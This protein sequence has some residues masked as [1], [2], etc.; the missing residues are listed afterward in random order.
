ML[1]SAPQG[2]EDPPVSLGIRSLDALLG[3][4]LPAGTL[5]SVRGKVG[6]GALRLTARALA[7]ATG[8][9]RWAAVVDVPGTL[10]PPGLYAAGVVLEGLLFVVPPAAGPCGLAV[11][12]AEE[13]LR[14]GAFPLV[15]LRGL[16]L[17]EGRGRRLLLAAEAG[18]SVGVLLGAGGPVVRAPC[19]TRLEVAPTGPGGG[20]RVRVVRQRGGASGRMVMVNGNEVY[21]PHGVCLAEGLPPSAPPDRVAVA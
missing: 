21:G 5:A 10:Y 3:G 16:R 14:H 18:R 13:L 8:A 7:E 4:G 1:H 12:A 2:S 6:G 11:R 20:L 17:D 9:G 19:A 15:V